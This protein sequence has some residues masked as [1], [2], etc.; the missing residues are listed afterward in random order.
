[1]GLPIVASR[2]GGIPELLDGNKGILLE[3]ISGNAIAEA[4]RLTLDDREAAQ[5]RSAVL[6][7]FI[8][9]QYSVEK[10]ARVFRERYRECIGSFHR[11]AMVQ[12]DDREPI[13]KERV[14]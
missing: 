10:N 2:T 12:M 8:T 14:L 4:V 13:M 1:V 9:E 3:T 7:V 11:P 5:Q 6:R